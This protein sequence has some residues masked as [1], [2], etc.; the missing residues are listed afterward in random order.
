MSH[1]DPVADFLTRIRNAS[2]AGLRYADIRWNK[3][4]ENI[5]EVLKDEQFLEHVLVRT[6]EDGVREMRVFLKY[7]PKRA[8]VIRGIR[9]SSTPGRR[10]FVGCDKVPSVLNGLGICIV[11][12]SQGVM[13]GRKAKESHIGGE[14]VCVVW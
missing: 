11:S 9:R 8:P 7:G 13:S 12:T 4:V 1:S 6:N 2:T 14:L 5:A 10:S 3:F